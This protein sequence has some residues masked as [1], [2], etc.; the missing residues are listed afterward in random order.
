V[1]EVFFPSGG[2]APVK[3][4]RGRFA[5]IVAIGAYFCPIDNYEHVIVA[6]R[7]GTITELW[8]GGAD[9][10]GSGVLAVIPGVTALCAFFLSRRPAPARARRRRHRHLHETW[11]IGGGRAMG[12]NTRGQV[13]GT[14]AL[15]GYDG[16]GDQFEHVIAERRRDSPRSVLDAIEP[17][18]S[19]NDRVQNASRVARRVERRGVAPPDERSREPFTMNDPTLTRVASIFTRGRSGAGDNRDPA[20]KLVKT[21]SRRSQRSSTRSCSRQV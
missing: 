7:D 15:A 10:G 18:G 11:F 19:G 8:F 4:V 2:A 1:H 20:C 13:P 9:A 16:T 5:D 14:I 6:T 3:N 12:H 21:T 17:K